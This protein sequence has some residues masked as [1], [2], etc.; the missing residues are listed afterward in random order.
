MSS[1]CFG[2]HAA[3]ASTRSIL[4]GASSRIDADDL[5]V[6]RRAELH[7]EHRILGRLLHLRAQLRLR[8]DADREARERRRRGI[9]PPQLVERH[10]EALAHEIVQRGPHGALRRA[11]AAPHAVHLELDRLERPRV[12]LLEDR[13]ELI[14]HRGDGLGILAVE[15]ARRRLAHAD[16]PSVS[17]I[18]TRLTRYSLPPPRA[19]VNGCFVRSE[20]ISCVSFIS[21][22][23]VMPSRRESHAFRSASPPAVC[24]R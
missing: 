16:A 9:E 20:T 18:F 1:A 4:S 8:R 6:V 24:E 17:V 10:A 5:L 21:R 11:V 23:G 3:F 13:R 12:G 22:V 2:V 15:A 14:E 19:M 7:L